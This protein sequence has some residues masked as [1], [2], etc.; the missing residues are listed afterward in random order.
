MFLQKH[1]FSGTQSLTNPPQPDQFVTPFF[2]PNFEHSYCWSSWFVTPLS[3]YPDRCTAR[4][5]A[6]S[7]GVLH[8]WQQRWGLVSLGFYLWLETEVVLR[9]TVFVLF[10]FKWNLGWNNHMM[11]WWLIMAKKEKQPTWQRHCF[12]LWN[13]RNTQ[14]LTPTHTYQVQETGSD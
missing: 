9:D 8:N 10:F 13:S 5:K 14:A 3:I 4:S 11:P 12:F 1:L 2:S 6:A 7:V